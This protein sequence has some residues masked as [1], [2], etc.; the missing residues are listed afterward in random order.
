MFL[1]ITAFSQDNADGATPKKN[2]EALFMDF[3][4]VLVIFIDKIENILNNHVSNTT[5]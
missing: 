2:N 1:P 4:D 3:H 5:F